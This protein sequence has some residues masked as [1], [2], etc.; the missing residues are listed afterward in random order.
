[1]EEGGF[2]EVWNT[3][4]EGWIVVSSLAGVG[5]T[6]ELN[7]DDVGNADNT[8]EGIWDVVELTERTRKDVS[9]SADKVGMS[10]PE[11]F[12]IDSISTK[13][14]RNSVSSSLS[15]IWCT[16]RVIESGS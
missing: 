3:E 7:G 5:T 14:S 11:D 2:G 10:V 9:F 8:L 13:L 15:T 16:E 4:V 1:M 12:N 6:V